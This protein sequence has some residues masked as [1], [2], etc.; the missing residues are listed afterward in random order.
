MRASTFIVVSVATLFNIGL[1]F[2]PRPG[3]LPL[4]NVGAC[5]VEAR[6]AAARMQD[7]VSTTAPRPLSVSPIGLADKNASNTSVRM[8]PDQPW[9]STVRDGVL[10]LAQTA[11]FFDTLKIADVQCQGAICAIAGSTQT[12]SDGHRHGNADV[13][14]LLNAIN[15]GQIAGGDTGRLASLSSVQMNAGGDGVDFTLSV[16][17]STGGFVNPCQSVFDLWNQMH[18][19]EWPNSFISTASSASTGSG[20]SG[21]S[22]PLSPPKGTQR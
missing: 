4:S 14:T 10:G 9:L 17:Q 20:N 22:A 6:K 15:N 19:G 2:W 1:W 8:S 18:P 16:E 11:A 3:P 13:A 21:A 5:A 7:E 12:S